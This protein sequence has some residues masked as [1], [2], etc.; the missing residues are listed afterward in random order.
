MTTATEVAWPATQPTVRR[1]GNAAT[2]LVRAEL[3]KIWTTNTWW[4]LAIVA[5]AGVGLAL[6]FNSVQAHFQISEALTPPD[7]TGGVKGDAGPSPQDIQ[8]MQQ[9]W[10]EQHN[11]TRIL[12]QSA[13]AIF[14][15]GQF[16]G[17][18]L[19][20]VFGT[21][22]VTN[23]FYH[24][25]ATTTFLTTP[26]RTSVILAKLAAATGI[27]AVTWLVTTLIDL[28]AGAIFFANEGQPNSLTDWPVERAILVNLPAYA[29]WAVFGVGL[30]VLIRSQIGATV[31][32]VGLYLVGTFLAQAAFFLI[33]QFLIKED[34]VIKAQVIVP[35]IASQIM[36]SAEPVPLGIK[37]DSSEVIYGPS[38]WVGALVLVAYGVVA[39]GIGTLITRKRDIS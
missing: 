25:T 11:L 8:N 26:K 19:V 5:L 16:I 3:L 6:L 22:L 2:R 32:G 28:G 13:A 37:P 18:M 35:A 17:L 7:F 20:M 29:I 38:W 36:I 14:T 12:Q 1:Q 10:L 39:A 15:S 9:Q 27:A 21:L 31:T 4:I 24:Q 23:E 34:W 30:G 33:H